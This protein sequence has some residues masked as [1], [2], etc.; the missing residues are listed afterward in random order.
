M[1]DEVNA[2]ATPQTMDEIAGNIQEPAKP[3]ATQ[4]A[5][6]NVEDFKNFFEKTSKTTEALQNQVDTISKA[7]DE[8]VNSQTLEAVNKEIK[9]IA[10]KINEKVG[11]DADLAELFLEKSLLLWRLFLKK[12]AFPSRPSPLKIIFSARR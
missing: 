1:T 4:N 3:D 8:L 10:E 6:D 2:N 11:G 9:G 12:R 7:H 5:P